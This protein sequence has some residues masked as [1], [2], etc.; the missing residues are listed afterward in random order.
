MVGCGW[1]KR[2]VADLKPAGHPTG[3]WLTD[4]WLTAGW[5]LADCWLT[6]CWVAKPLATTADEGVVEIVCCNTKTQTHRHTVCRRLKVV[7]GEYKQAQM[8]EDRSIDTLLDTRAKGG[9]GQADA[10]T[11]RTWLSLTTPC[12][13]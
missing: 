7:D 4:C 10:Q 9:Q 12:F 8:H 3:C 6:G 5:L 1:K 2:N 11:P 13:V